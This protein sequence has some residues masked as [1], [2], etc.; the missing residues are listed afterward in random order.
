MQNALKI[1]TIIN[2]ELNYKNWFLFKELQ[3]N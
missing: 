2:T 1:V 3:E